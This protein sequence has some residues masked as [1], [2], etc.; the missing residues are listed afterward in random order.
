MGDR[1]FGIILIVGFWSFWFGMVF[2]FIY[3][4]FKPETW[5]LNKVPEPLS[6]NWRGPAQHYDSNGTFK[7]N[8]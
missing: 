1:I 7:G 5:W 3:S 6:S 4:R 2:L 8:W